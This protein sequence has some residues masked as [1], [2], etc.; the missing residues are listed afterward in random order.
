MIMLSYIIEVLSPPVH[1]ESIMDYG[2][3]RWQA[4]RS[5]SPQSISPFRGMDWTMDWLPGKKRTKEITPRVHVESTVQI[6]L[7]LGVKTPS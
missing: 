4:P 6:S 2:L 1:S 5:M 7:F 3:N